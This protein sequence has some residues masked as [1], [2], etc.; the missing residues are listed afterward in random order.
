MIGPAITATLALA[1]LPAPAPLPAA[2]E[3]ADVEVVVQTTLNHFAAENASFLEQLLLLGS[4]DLGTFA[5][6]RLGPGG[7]VVYPFPRGT[8][9]DLHVEVV[10]IDGASWRNTGSVSLSDVRDSRLGTMWVQGSAARSVAWLA[11]D[12]GLA[13]M[14]PTGTLCS[15]A[16]RASRPE[17]ETFAA[18]APVHVPT[19]V[20]TRDDKEGPPPVLDKKPLPPV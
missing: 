15:A 7:R 3:H 2:L 16:M 9:D 19:P 17:L 13:Y 5:A 4:D 8:A 12:E 18:P 10:A 14:R 6:L 11:V 1:Q 20:P